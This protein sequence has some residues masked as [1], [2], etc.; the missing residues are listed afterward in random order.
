MT[1]GEL[2]T[3]LALS[4]GLAGAVGIFV[5]VYWGKIRVERQALVSWVPGLSTLLVVPGMLVVLLSSNTT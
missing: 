4:T 3:W 5:A 1:T 2:G